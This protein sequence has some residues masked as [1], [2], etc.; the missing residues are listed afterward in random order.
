MISKQGGGYINRK[1][2]HEKSAQRVEQ[3]VKRVERLQRSVRGGAPRAQLM[4]E[5]SEKASFEKRI[6]ICSGPSTRIRRWRSTNEP[7]L[8][9]SDCKPRG[10]TTVVSLRGVRHGGTLI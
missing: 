5:E 3:R 4:S 1:I 8:T 2:G 6:K 7:I 10:T 9:K